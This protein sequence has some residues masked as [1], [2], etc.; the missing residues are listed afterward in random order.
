MPR[1]TPTLLAF[2]LALAACTTARSADALPRY[3]LVIRNGVVYDGSGSPPQ[4]VDVAV[5]DG[6][7]VELLHAG[8]AAHA[9]KE[10]DAGGKA[11]APGFI[12]VLSWATESLIVDG[13]GV[14]DTKQGVTLEIFGEGWSMGPVNERMK[15]DAL[16]Q[17]AD[18]RYDIPW[19]TLGGYLEHLQQRGV[20]PN[21]ASF[22]GTATVRIH[23]LGEDDVKPTPEQLSRMQDVV[24]QAMREGAL[25][26]GS[27]LIYPPGGFAETD[28]LI[29]LAKAAAESG[30]G[31]ISHMR[32]EADRLLEG[33]DEVVAIARAT[34]QHAEI[35]HLKAAGEKN[36]PKMQQAIDRIEAARKEGLKLS[37][38]MYVYTAGGTWLAASMPPWLQAG[39]HDAMIRRL[40]DP[41]TRA[42]LIAEMRDPNVPWENL[43]ML[44]ASDE[45]LVPI[46]FKSE[47]L[48]P[49]AGKSLAAI[50]RERGTSVEE[51]AMDLI[52][53]D[54][55]RIGTAY[56]LMSEDNIELG[57]KQP[58]V[59]LGSDA[60]SAAP[61]GVFLK[62]STHPRAYG[63]VA[64]FLGH[65][66]RDRKLMPLEEG[67]HRL[68]GLPASN[69][70]LTD[71]GCL[72]AGCHADIVIF[73]PGTITD[74]ATYEEPQQYATGVSDVF[75]N[76]V[77]VL[78]EGEHTGATPG[79][80][81][82]G[83]GWTPATR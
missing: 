65:Y 32:S 48:K 25:G 47:A 24:R 78:R 8:K 22:I 71:R 81:V 26:V 75:V 74:H 46:E 15:A 45:R 64:R 51:T 31:Y 57:L 63:N 16:K 34:G 58:W 40:K 37:A 50:A 43:R 30:G 49:L 79:Q 21:V 35:Y 67:I 77:Q 23:E 62:S 68:T 82:R 2:T 53:E 38:D 56:F 44:A 20:T 29:A 54:D 59:S 55:H 83:P 33:I 66:V 39:G 10:I 73:D 60:E 5:R 80:V 36:W 1:F 27:S 28:E 4:R 19:T 17:Q 13:R 12:N 14:S 52:V 9:G 3:D 61:E 72:R 42:R 7:I 11:V 6:R 18:I 69:W 70:K 76:G 41:A